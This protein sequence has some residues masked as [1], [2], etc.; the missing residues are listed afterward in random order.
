MKPLAF[1]LLF[2]LSG[3][4]IFDGYQDNQHSWYHKELTDSE[5]EEIKRSGFLYKEKSIK[6]GNEYLYGRLLII[7]SRKQNRYNFIEIGDWSEERSYWS[8]GIIKGMDKRRT[9]YDFNG[10][11][12]SR[13]VWDK[14]K[15]QEDYYLLESIR[16]HFQIIN[17]DSLLIQK[18]TGYYSSGIKKFEVKVAVPAYKEKLSDRLKSKVDI[19][20]A[21]IYNEDGRLKEM[22][23][24]QSGLAKVK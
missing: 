14:P 18:I 7:E 15:S 12:L 9:L 13:E 24:S 19:D 17:G 11:I 6:N 22:K 16:S 5:K 8:D 23:V 21:F 10:N 4:A 3:C 1:I 20:T 2:F